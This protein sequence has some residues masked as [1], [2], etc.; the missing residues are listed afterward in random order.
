MQLWLRVNRDVPGGTVIVNLATLRDSA[1][2]DD[3]SA[4]TTVVKPPPHP[5][6]H[7]DADLDETGLGDD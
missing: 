1:G 7:V 2:S 4:E 3:A 6:P 5:G